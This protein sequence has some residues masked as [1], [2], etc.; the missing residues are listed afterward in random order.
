[1]AT[2]HHQSQFWTYE[3]G[4]APG[5]SV[6]L[7]YGPDDKYKTGT[8]QVYAYPTTQEGSS[9]HNQTQTLQVQPLFSSAVP[10]P[11]FV[12]GVASEA[13]VGFNI[14]NAGQY[15]IRQF[16]LTITVIGP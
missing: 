4:I 6:W 13:Y 15:T 3:N 11:D 7:S 1:M 12:G 16:W 14:T 10:V 9:V 5:Q 2:I 8:V